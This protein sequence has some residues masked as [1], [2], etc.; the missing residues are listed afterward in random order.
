MFKQFFN[1]KEK[2]RLKRLK[3][4]QKKAKKFAERY[5]APMQTIA[6]K[7]SLADLFKDA[8]VAEFQPKL[9]INA[10]PYATMYYATQAAVGEVQGFGK[11]RKDGDVYT[12]TEVI[13]LSQ[14]ASGGY[15]SLDE[16][17][18]NEFLYRLASQ[19]KDPS[20]FNFSWHS[21]AHMGVFWS[22]VDVADIGRLVGNRELIS[23]VMNK[24]G[25]MLA[26]YDCPEFSLN[27]IPIAIVPTG[28]Q[29][30]QKDAYE[31][32]KNKVGVYVHPVVEGALVPLLL[33]ELNSDD[34]PEDEDEDLVY[35]VHCPK[36]KWEGDL[37]VDEDECPQC[38]HEPLDMLEDVSTTVAEY[39]LIHCKQ[40]GWKGE[41]N[42]LES[43]CP[44][45][46][47]GNIL[48]VGEP[49][50]FLQ[51]GVEIVKVDGDF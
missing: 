24:E 2:K 10:V 15:T 1:R 20:D 14:T 26:R 13:I 33:N 22:G 23:V 34:G 51:P 25:A 17:A 42:V 38:G 30:I 32:V 36:C 4:E 44:L 27:K 29:D 12:V 5:G 6:Q 50:R 41:V 11:F 39:H 45:C 16:E 31:Q 9:K 28:M 18:M 47:S 19:G 46:R 8:K 35:R 3:R 37:S 48:K 43:K 49:K 21:H 7:P 40:C